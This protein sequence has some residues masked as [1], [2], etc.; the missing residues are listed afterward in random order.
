MDAPVTTMKANFHARSNSLPS[1]SHPLVAD[2]EDQLRRL[3]ASEA[4]TSSPS[5]LCRNL[6]VL[7]EM[8]ECAND[9]FQLPLSQKAFSN[10][11]HD[12]YVED[13]LDGSLKLLD[14]CSS[15]SDALSQINGCVQDLESSLRRRNGCESSL[16]NEIRKYFTLRKQL[17]K[18]VCKCFGNIKRMQKRNAAILDN[19]HDFE[20]LVSMLKE[21]E[22]VSLT[23]FESLLSFVYSPKSKSTGWSLVSK[24][25]QSKRV[26]CEIE[27]KDDKIDEALEALIKNKSGK[28]IDVTQ[29]QK[30]LKNLEAFESTIQELKE[31]LECAFRCLIKTRV[32]LFNIVNH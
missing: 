6:A 26:S 29:V 22:A 16:A 28:S 3:R 30:A 12:K 4:T 9:L 5:S 18:I 27:D 21:V 10:D 32:S 23:V 20:L 8:H 19:D 14:I 25:I 17:N 2:I 13:M 24:L 11:R 31:G 1:K 7:K 15:S